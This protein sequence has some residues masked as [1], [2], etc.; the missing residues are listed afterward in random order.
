VRVRHP[1][2]LADARALA[3]LLGEA[4]SSV[5]RAPLDR[6]GSTLTGTR[7]ERLRAVLGDG[8]E[9]SLVLKRARIGA[10]WVGRRSGDVLGREAALLASTEAAPVWD[11]L[12][13]PYLAYA[14]A[15]G[16]CAVLMDDLSP[17][18]LPEPPAPMPT[19]HEDA[20]LRA[21][22][23]L[24]ERF[25]GIDRDAMPWAARPVARFGLL[26]PRAPDEEARL[27]SPAALFELVRRG[28]AEAFR[29]LPG[30]LV[31]LLSAPPEE[32]AAACDGLPWTLLHGD[33]KWA[34]FALGPGARVAAF[35]WEGAALGPAALELGYVLAISGARSQRSREA[36]FE[37]YRAAVPGLALADVGR[38]RQS[39]PHPG[40]LPLG[41]GTPAGSGSDMWRRTFDL[42]ILSGANLL[43][44]QKALVERSD[45]FEWWAAELDHRW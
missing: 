23:T 4:V 24:H 28:W 45:D 15:D 9:R 7:L 40:P 20:L 34:N 16:D 42:A 3:G 36:I 2:A 44:W 43:L 8:G 18:L 33:A 27:D 1:D 39:G 31:D 21:L 41:E 30:R 12:D 26:H 22:G 17:W 5:E 35:D 38:W 6:R 19:E 25:W 29:R 13:C 37:A 11:A 32:L 14:V 10:S